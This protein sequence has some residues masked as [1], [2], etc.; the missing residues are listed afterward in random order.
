MILICLQIKS[1]PYMQIEG[2]GL[3]SSLS[4]WR[5]AKI[6]IENVNLNH[7]FPVRLTI[8]YIGTRT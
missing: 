8:Y 7:F 2:A 3:F 4:K 6:G 5:G 1:N